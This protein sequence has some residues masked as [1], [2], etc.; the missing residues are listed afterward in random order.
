L[1]ARTSAFV[2]PLLPRALLLLPPRRACIL[3][4]VVPRA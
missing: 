3:G 1:Q 4:V 2:Q